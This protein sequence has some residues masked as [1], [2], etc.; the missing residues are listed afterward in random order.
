MAAEYPALVSRETLITSEEGRE[1]PQLILGRP[2]ADNKPIVLIDCGMHA[3]EWITPAFCQ[4]YVNRVSG[5]KCS[6]NVANI[7]K[8]NQK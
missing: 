1:I 4:C 8:F 7:F 3:R 6:R 5:R 2:L